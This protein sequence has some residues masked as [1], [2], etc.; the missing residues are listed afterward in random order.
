MLLKD[1]AHSNKILDLHPASRLLPLSKNHRKNGKSQ[2]M[3]EIEKNMEREQTVL[4]YKG[5][6]CSMPC[7][8]GLA[9][10]QRTLIQRRQD[11]GDLDLSLSLEILF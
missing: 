1:K 6:S 2:Q 5:W 11:G 8:T 3:V 10:S 7:T 9:D 4:T